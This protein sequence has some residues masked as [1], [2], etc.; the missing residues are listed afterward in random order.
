MFVGPIG[1]CLC[2]C[3]YVCVWRWH[4]EWNRVP[5]C[6]AGWPAASAPQH[7]T[8]QTVHRLATSRQSLVK[9]PVNAVV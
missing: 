5:W 7:H 4:K 6:S 9:S 1:V 3:V 2:V 8:C